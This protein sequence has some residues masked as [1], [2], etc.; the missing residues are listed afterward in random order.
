MATSETTVTPSN[1]TSDDIAFDWVNENFSVQ[2]RELVKD[3]PWSR[4]YRLQGNSGVAYLKLIPSHEKGVLNKT[5]QISR[6][7]PATVPEVTA[8]NGDLGLLIMREFAGIPLHDDPTEV[9]I[10]KLLTTYADMQ[11]AA[12]QNKELLSELPWFKLDNIIRNFFEFLDPETTR[13][14]EVG[15]DYFLNPAEAAGYFKALIVRS[16][17]LEDMLSRV[18]PLP[19]TLNHCDLHGGNTAE[20]PDG[21]MIIFDWD[22]AI[23]GPAGLSLHR[24]LGGCSG[25]YR[26]L[27]GDPDINQEAP[28]LQRLFS[29]YANRLALGGYADYPV[30]IDAMPAAVTVGSMQSISLYGKFPEDNEEYRESIAEILR[31]RL[32]D[33]LELCDLLTLNSRQNTIEFVNDYLQNGVPWRATYLLD[34]YLSWHPNDEELHGWAATLH[35][36]AG[37]WEAAMANFATLLNTHP[38]RAESHFNMGVALLKSGQPEQAMQ[39]FETTQKIDDAFD[40]ASEYLAKASDI[41]ERLQRATV[42]HLAPAVRLSDEEKNSNTVESENLDLAT[43]MFREH[44]YVVMENLFPAELIREISDEFFKRYNSYFEDRLYSDNLILGDKRRMVSVALE[45]AL[46]S[47]RLYGST[48]V[49][50]LMKR[51]LGDDYV[52]GSYNAVVS[53]PGAQPKGLHKDYP[54][55]FKNDPVENHVTPPF[56]ISVLFPLIELT[57]EHGI[58][59]MRKGTHLLP[60]ETPFDAPEQKPLLKLGDAVIF[61]YCTAHDGLANNT[62]SVR[63][64]LAMV[65]HRVWFRDALNYV[66]QKAIIITPEEMEKVPDAQKHLF[67]WAQSDG[68][69]L[70]TDAI[71]AWN[72]GI[73]PGGMI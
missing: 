3:H 52:M 31:K 28:H 1:F 46:N 73:E 47:P 18:A 2:T 30:L 41:V 10:R 39:A 9:Q 45:G 62:D 65:F 55:L 63:P 57:E 56:A 32:D 53:L 26:L 44:G 36:N 5:Q 15:A 60:D 20:K 35:M 37:Q 51:L 27:N 40:G 11:V 24:L 23:I 42:P 13:Q 72:K 68:A 67:R 19:P 33:L 71:E 8:S 59:S 50:E 22:D 58:T 14:G 17:I 69:E 64:L 4:V 12:S 54:P 66:H 49:V 25:L 7:F 16:E 48:L 61:D 21:S 43:R 70:K 34:K 29:A 38:E 6:H